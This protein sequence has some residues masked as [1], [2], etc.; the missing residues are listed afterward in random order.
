[1]L[2]NLNK[3][4]AGGF[5]L[6]ELLVVIAIIAILA[7]MLLPALASAKE[8]S[9][10]IACVNNLRQIAIGVTVYAGDNN[11]YVLPVR[12][13]VPNTLTDPGGVAATS[14]G[15]ITQTNV[16]SI[17]ACPNRPGLPLHEAT[18]NPAPDN[19]QWTLGYC[20][21]GGLTAWS[22]DAG[23][24][25]FKSHSPVKLSSSKPYWVLGVDTLISA[26]RTTWNGTDVASGP[27]AT[28]RNQ[29]V[30]NHCPP[31]LKGS[32]TAGGNEAYAD[33]SASFQKWDYVNWHCF[34]SWS[35]ALSTTTEVYWKQDTSDFSPTELGFL[36]VIQPSPLLP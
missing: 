25:A 7:A 1:M 20:Y 24:N 10:R 6:I 4:P 29:L 17:W 16:S 23:A 30:Y 5:T 22:S 2:K 11:D 18:A 33:G 3:K 8:K 28:A 27:D 34:T 35:G 36:P 13:G 32:H 19:F 14:V 12:G 15:L 31:H 21:L 9:K 26:G